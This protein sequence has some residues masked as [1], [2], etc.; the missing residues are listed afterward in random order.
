M[1][2]EVLRTNVGVQVWLGIF[3]IT[4][5]VLTAV[6]V[7]MSRAESVCWRAFPAPAPVLWVAPEWLRWLFGSLCMAATVG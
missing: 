4:A 3:A 7:L 5:L 2:A 6:A 1:I